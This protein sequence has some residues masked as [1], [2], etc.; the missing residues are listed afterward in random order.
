MTDKV[1]PSQSR[2]AESLPRFLLSW[3]P[4]V[5][6]PAA[7]MS[8]SPF[9]V[10]RWLSG[11]GGVPISFLS[12]L[13]PVYI[14]LAVLFF[15][16][17]AVSQWWALR[18]YLPHAGRWGIMTLV[19]GMAGMLC[20]V[21]GEAFVLP[22]LLSLSGMSSIPGGTS[23]QLFFVALEG[24]L[25]ASV[26]GTAQSL[27]ASFGWR[28]RILWIMCSAVS[29]G[30]AFAIVWFAQTA[31]LSVPRAFFGIAVRLLGV[32]NLLSP[33]AWAAYALA[34]GL[35]MHRL[36]TWRQRTQQTSVVGRFD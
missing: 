18:R 15:C 9:E 4:V 6:A 16:A 11:A 25:F 7:V 21:A 10:L 27:A 14:G 3:L 35:V 36:M 29:G 13:L 8:A 30:L 20:Y 17:A 24:V 32:G 2:S 5:L 23:G 26:M 1:Q 28:H 34:M 19:G 33:V 22:S 31:I 12:F